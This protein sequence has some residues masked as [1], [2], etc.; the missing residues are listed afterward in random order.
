MIFWNGLETVIFLGIQVRAF[1][2]HFQFL[3]LNFFHAGVG[4]SAKEKI[5]VQVENLGS[6]R[7][8]TEYQIEVALCISLVPMLSSSFSLLAVLQYVLQVTKSWL[9][10]WE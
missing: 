3:R 8:K 4:Q 2:L 6:V 1:Q 5:I 10:A 9:R 7:P